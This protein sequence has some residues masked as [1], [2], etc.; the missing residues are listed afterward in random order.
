MIDKLDYYMV[1][2]FVQPNV[3]FIRYSLKE[4]QYIR[5]SSSKTDS[6]MGNFVIPQPLFAIEVSYQALLMAS[7]YLDQNI[8]LMEEYDSS[9]WPTLV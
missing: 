3:P 2:I 8:P 4:F 6:L 1:G 7:S 9:T 5:V